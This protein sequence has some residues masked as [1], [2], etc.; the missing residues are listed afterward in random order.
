MKRKTIILLLFAALFAAAM[1]SCGGN[2]I[3]PVEEPEEELL[4]DTTL[5]I[6]PEGGTHRVSIRSHASWKAQVVQGAA[7]C[8]LTPTSGGSGGATLAVSAGN[9]DDMVVRTALIKIESEIG[10]GTIAVVQQQ[11]DVLDLTMDDSTEF[12]PQGGTFAVKTQYNIDYEI[13]CSADWVHQV[14]SKALQQATLA[15]AVDKN[16]S[17]AERSCELHFSGSGIDRTVT[18]YQDEAYVHLS[19]N[20]LYLGNSDTYLPMM[21]ESNISYRITM[22]QAD[23]LKHKGEMDGGR[24]GEISAASQEFELPENDGFLLR[25]CE[26]QFSNPDYNVTTTLHLV[27]KARDILYEPFPLDVFGPA[28]GSFTFDLDPTVQYTLSNGDAAWIQIE[29]PEDCPYRRVITV[30][31][32]LSGEDRTGRL[33]IKTDARSK[34]LDLAQEGAR[35][36]FSAERFTYPSMGGSQQLSVSGN[37]E[38]TL[39]K[40]SD[41]PWCRVEEADGG[42]YSIIV[43]RNQD[44]SDREC[45]LVFSNEEYK[46]EYSIP[47]VQAQ[48]DAF[49]V[50]PAAFEIAPQGGRIE[51]DIHANVEFECEIDSDWIAEYTAGRTPSK[52]VY[53]VARFSGLGSRQGRLVFKGAGIE[54]TVAVAQTGGALSASPRSFEFG[55]A[56]SSGSFSV[57][58]N[59]AFQAKVL[60]GDWLTIAQTSENEVQFAL[61]ENND[62]GNRSG[63]I[64]VFNPDYEAADTVTIYQGA[65]FYLDIEQTEF[66]LP[67]QGGK[68]ELKVVSNKPYDYRIADAPDWIREASPLV[69]EIAPNTSQLARQAQIIFEQNGLQKNVTITQDAPYLALDKPQLEF[70]AAGGQATFSVSGNVPFEL[71]ASDAGWLECVKTSASAY[72]V[73]VAENELPEERQAVLTV[74]SAAYGCSASL[75]V[76]QA[77]KGIF[78]LITSEFSLGPEGGAVKVEVNTNVE[79]SYSSPD[80]WI[81]GG[82]GLEFAVAKNLSEEV[83]SGAI[84]FIANGYTYTVAVQQ[85][86]AQL[87]VS[88]VQLLFPVG[89]GKASFA[90]TGNIGYELSLP[91]E[92][93]LSCSK[94]EDGN[95][96]VT[97]AANEGEADRESAIYVVS[98]EFEREIKIGLRQPRSDFFTLST[99]SFELG[100]DQAEIEVELSTNID[101]T[102]SVSAGWL[103]DLG[104]LKFAAERNKGSEAR[105][106]SIDFVA[107][108]ETYS[109]SVSQQA[110]WLNVSESRLDVEFTGGSGSVQVEANVPFTA[111]L[112]ESDWVESTAEGGKY[113]FVIS[114]NE[115]YDVRSYTVSF[116]AEDFGLSKSFKI[117]QA[118]DESARPFALDKRDNFIGPTGGR[119]EITHTP[120]S[121]V[122]VSVNGAG[123]IR[124]IPAERSDTRLVFSVDT[125][126]SSVTRQAIVSVIGKGRTVTGY[127]FQNT[128][129]MVL[130]YHDRHFRAPGGTSSIEMTSNFTPEFYTDQDWVSGSVAPDGESISFTAAANDTGL[131][132][133]AVVEVG[134]KRLGYVQEVTITQEAND[135]VKVSPAQIAAGSEGGEYHVDVQANVDFTMMTSETWFSYSR[136]DNVITITVSPNTSAAGRSGSLR[137]SG[138]SADAYVQIRQ[139]GYR[140]PDYYYSEDFSQHGV[141]VKLQSASKG[142]GVPLV[143][144]GD[145]FSDRQIADGTYERRMRQAVEAIFAIEPYKTFRELFNIWYVN[146]VS[147]NEIY[148]DDASTAL[149]TKFVKGSVVSGNHS[150]VYRMVQNVLNPIEMR[151]VAMV[152]LMN[153]ETYGGSTYFYDYIGQINGDYGLGESIAYIPLCTSQEQFTQV[154]Q[155]EIGGHAI[156]KLDDEYYYETSA[157]ITADEI[158]NYRKFQAAGFFRNVDFTPEPAEVLWAKFITDEDYR[159]D[160]LGVFEGAC[161]R[162]KGAYRPTQESMMFHNE[163]PFNAP[164]REAI[165]YRLHKVAF[166]TSWQYDYEQFKQYDAINRRT[167][168]QSSPAARRSPSA[169]GPLCPSP[170][171]HPQH[172]SRD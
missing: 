75:K 155:H 21:V 68:A 94:A 33:A 161:I 171:P 169:T 148:A 52:R 28:G 5:I 109:V 26:V 66:S 119:L 10:K 122:Q 45:A 74:A 16:N 6:L 79:Y 60:E 67:P 69:F 144:L 145:A 42:V 83:R 101:Y 160:G 107:A 62:W 24:D 9:N 51:V 53:D 37:V 106:C 50:A 29:T 31:K 63:R 97:A 98:E 12:G 47:V 27:Q 126:F 57:G 71:T 65:K 3:D 168:P 48:L 61:S 114:T 38:Y 159:Y 150:T 22:P 80:S 84:E 46:L 73:T 115:G 85:E 138:G 78:E 39:E 59:I 123:W 96:V 125:M 70:A 149:E 35:L 128:P 143:L 142:S 167:T 23:W 124:E 90:V 151:N 172:L 56:P 134:L 139:E 18:V 43:A 17:G 49:E 116:A 156:G 82:E 15:F 131:E 135:V 137:V 153:T 113:S 88:P 165:Y 55:D 99:T 140:N 163:G 129:L 34:N 162:S 166:G 130:T 13:S 72:K 102:Y 2:K 103:K 164:S 146:V 20:E 8:K 19:V 157:A 132:R 152:V 7:W 112:P 32:N 89:G 120:C 86:A 64:A 133:T 91:D 87:E 121:D 141:A 154:L 110:P 93:W 136:E 25:E 76:V 44:E 104:G 54:H 30:E 100:P 41:A 105:Q 11:I 108:G 81:S 147:M 40:P 118:G 117:V 14:P 4:I 95:Y 158:A 127:V 1:A 92:D 58:G 170:L 36:D 77:E 111:D